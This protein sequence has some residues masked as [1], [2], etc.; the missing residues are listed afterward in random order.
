[1]H[2]ADCLRHGNSSGEASKAW[3]C[4]GRTVLG[5]GMNWADGLGHRN[6]LG[7]VSKTWECIGRIA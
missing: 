1:M 6:A 3:E 4:I 2:W 7:G 5:M